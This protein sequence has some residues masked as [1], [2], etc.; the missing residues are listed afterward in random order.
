MSRTIGTILLQAITGDIDS[1]NI[2]LKQ[3]PQ[4]ITDAFIEA[5]DQGDETQRLRLSEVIAQ[6]GRPMVAPLIQALDHPNTQVRRFATWSL[7]HMMDWVSEVPTQRLIDIVLDER[8]DAMTHW[9]AI[10]VLQR[11]RQPQAIPAIIQK[12]LSHYNYDVQAVSAEAL[13]YLGTADDNTVNQALIPLLG[14]PQ[15]YVRQQA[16]YALERL[17]GPEQYRNLLASQM[18][19]EPAGPPPDIGELIATAMYTA[20]SA[21]RNQAIISLRQRG[22]EPVEPLMEVLHRGDNEARLAVSEVIQTMGGIMV[23]P[24]LQALYDPDS[25]V[26]RFAAFNLGHLQ[27]YEFEP[28]ITRLMELAQHADWSV[29][30]SAIF[31]L[32]RFRADGAIDVILT[33]LKHPNH[34]IRAVS[35]E[36]LGLIGDP[37]T[38]EPLSAMFQDTHPHVLEQ[39]VRALG[40]FPNQ[41]LP[42]SFLQLYIEHGL[43]N[44]NLFHHIQYIPFEIPYS[45]EWVERLMQPQPISPLTIRLIGMMRDERVVPLLVSMLGKY[46]SD[47]EMQLSVLEALG[48][49]QQESAVPPMIES[50]DAFLAR[51]SPDDYNTHSSTTL[52]LMMAL[53]SN[54]S[55]SAQ[56]Y[57]ETIQKPENYALHALATCLAQQGTDEALAA[58]IDLIGRMR[59]DPMAVLG[60]FHSS[61]IIYGVSG[62]ED[63]LIRLTKAVLD[64]NLPGTESMAYNLAG[65]LAY[66][67]LNEFPRVFIERL[68]ADDEVVRAKA[69]QII[70]II[71]QQF[72]QLAYEMLPE[73]IGLSESHQ[74][75]MYS[76]N[77]IAPLIVAWKQQR[78]DERRSGYIKDALL[79][80][81]IMAVPLLR[82]LQQDAIA[83]LQAEARVLLDEIQQQNH[84]W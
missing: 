1:Q 2:I 83:G 45:A 38:F 14:D 50:I 54:L 73:V 36:A 62:S 44:P 79:A 25:Q 48:S 60:I 55:P 28:P 17:M 52:R 29:S 53:A 49:T 12:G 80:A 21:A 41:R 70:R 18:P 63:H 57:L 46:Q 7:G 76:Q 16:G 69:L 59:Q 61:F 4:T 34:D 74:K 82:E 42:E 20:D 22:A 23:S 30:W 40:H 67:R 56:R 9:A 6:M 32:G 3:T 19:K 66:R 15:E 8:E 75:A 84:F 37:R 43:Q 77:M 33:G 81:G 10:W 13:S 51:L 5:L 35:V 64:L 39:T 68:T 72:V 27:G 31:A 47:L 26:N 71:T 24:L 65:L 11:F 78:N 58:L